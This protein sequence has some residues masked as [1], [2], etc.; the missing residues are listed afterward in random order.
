MKQETPLPIK[1][2]GLPEQKEITPSGAITIYSTSTM[3]LHPKPIRPEV[4]ALNDEI[5][6]GLA[7]DDRDDY[8]RRDDWDDMVAEIE[9]DT[10]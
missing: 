7:D 3:K 4:E 5:A 6:T 9:S 1:A 8:P 10:D 2:A